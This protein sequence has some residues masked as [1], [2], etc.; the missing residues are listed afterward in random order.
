Q[1]ELHRNTVIAY[2][3]KQDEFQ[4]WCAEK[5]FLPLASQLNVTEDKLHQFLAERVIDRPVR[6]PVR[7]NP[8]TGGPVHVGRATIMAYVSAAVDLWK[9]QGFL[10]INNHP[11]PNGPK[12]KQL[13]K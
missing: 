1:S 12:V 10:G 7:Y 9:H 6:R 2:K 11:N 5:G 13:L 4:R 3:Y 8:T